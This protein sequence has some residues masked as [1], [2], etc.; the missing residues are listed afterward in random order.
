MI[1][2]NSLSIRVKDHTTQQPLTILDNVTFKILDG[3]ISCF[4]GKSGAGK[5]SLLKAVGGLYPYE[6]SILLDGKELKSLSVQE[7]GQL[8]GFV[9]QQ[10][11]L[12]PHMTVLE[13]CTHP[14]KNLHL[15]TE[16]E[17]YRKAHEK[18]KL[19]GIDDLAHRYPSQLSGGQQQRVAIARALT[20]SPRL[21]L[22]DEPTSALDPES[23]VAL[24]LILKSLVAQGI[25]IAFS[26]HDMSFVRGLIDVAYFLERG[27]I[28]ETYDARVDVMP[29]KIKSFLQG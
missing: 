19:L 25:T 20:L 4:I 18:L 7:R 6:G 16:E 13:N 5:T 27:K 11:N 12:F 22:F 24:Q 1:T 8:L 26:S 9:F 28:V 3:R 15:L 10:F 17:A 2:A 14:L 21:L 29:E 23:S